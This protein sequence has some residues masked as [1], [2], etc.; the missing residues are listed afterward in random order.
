M[1]AS[2]NSTWRVSGTYFETCN[3]EAA[4]PCVF[5]SPPTS[6]TCTALVAWHIEQGTFGGTNLDG[7]NVA[8]AVHSPGHMLKTKWQVAL[9]LD[10]RA[11]PPQ[12]DA[13]GKIFSGQAGGHLAHVA[14][15]IGE[16]L[17]VKSAP[18][19]YYAEGKRRSLRIGEVASAEIEATSGADGNPPAIQNHPLCVAPGFP[20]QVARSKHAHFHDF[21]LDL[22]V[23]DKNGFY[24]PFS[25]QSA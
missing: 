2:S 5:L 17:G 23:S 20:V 4:C 18:I 14:Q 10:Q 11:T 8:L 21:G 7:L 12:S 24:S 3:C 15:L 19:E 9:Y 16:V 13:L 22:E 25:Y 1:N 6:G